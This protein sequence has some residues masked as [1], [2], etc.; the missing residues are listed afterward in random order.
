LIIEKADFGEELIDVDHFFIDFRHTNFTRKYDD[1]R[2]FRTLQDFPEQE[3]SSLIWTLNDMNYQQINEQRIL[4]AIIDF[5]FE[6]SRRP[7]II[8]F[9]CYISFFVLPFLLIVENLDD[10]LIFL[11]I[12]LMSTLLLSVGEFLQFMS[13]NAATTYLKI[14]HYFSSVWNLL[15]ITLCGFFYMYYFTQ[16][17]FVQEEST[18]LNKTFIRLFQSCLIL[19]IV[20]KCMF[21]SRVWY[22]MG[23][24][25]ELVSRVIKQS[26]SFALFF[27]GWIYVFSVIMKILGNEVVSPDY[28]GVHDQLKHFLYIYRNSIGDIQPPQYIDLYLEQDENPRTVY[29]MMFILWVFWFLNQYF[30]LIILLN[31]LIAIIS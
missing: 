13:F 18:F 8:Q 2:H 20:A 15:D 6:W 28:A 14:R 21:Y 19:L 10:H 12:C 29:F 7:F 30:C 22:S 1:L 5:Q 26:T 25:V 3:L 31:F 17:L 4:R 23:K 11:H 27:F 16:M 24:L 9:L